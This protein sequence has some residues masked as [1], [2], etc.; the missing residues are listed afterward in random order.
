MRLR[1]TPVV[2]EVLLDDELVVMVGLQVMLLSPLASRLLTLLGGEERTLA[3]VAD[4][5]AAEFGDPGDGGAAMTAQVEALVAGG[6]VV[7]SDRV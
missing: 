7:V 6:L 5:L 4:E 3:E 2:D 1:R